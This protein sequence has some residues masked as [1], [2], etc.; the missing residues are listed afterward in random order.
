MLRLSSGVEG[1]GSRV[2]WTGVAKALS[3][4]NIPYPN[5]ILPSRS[6]KRP[7]I[8]SPKPRVPC[9]EALFDFVSR[10]S[11]F[12]VEGLGFRDV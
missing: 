11:G 2:F 9:L 1:L 10:V 6:A 8:L 12:R 5:K 4:K 7:H 3:A